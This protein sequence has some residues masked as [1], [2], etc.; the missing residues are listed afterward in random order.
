MATHY[1]VTM[2]VP[3]SKSQNQLFMKKNLFLYLA[4]LLVSIVAG[5]PVLSSC[6]SDGG[7]SDDGSE[8]TNYTTK[9]YGLWKGESTESSSIIL[10]IRLNSD[11]TGEFRYLHMAGSSIK[12]YYPDIRNY[13]CDGTSLWLSFD[14]NT[15]VTLPIDLL[16]ENL[17]RLSYNGYMF[18]LNREESGSDDGSDTGITPKAT[19]TCV[20][21]A[22]KLSSGS[23][24]YSKSIRTYYKKNVGGR[25]ALY[26]TSTCSNLIG[27][28]SSNSDSKRG[29]FIVSSYSYRIVEAVSTSGTYYYYFN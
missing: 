26:T 18:N 15:S 5:M 25:V 23:R 4:M 29:D 20:I 2:P 12:H 16:S 7:G 11:K 22:T 9:I 28:G 17:M 8:P 10:A 1:K 21:Q 6:G 19:S 13:S 3:P 14:D 27:F 24:S